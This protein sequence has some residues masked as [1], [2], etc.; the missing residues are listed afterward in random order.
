M[1]IVGEYQWI[2]LKRR[3]VARFQSASVVEFG[4]TAL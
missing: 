3:Q 4:N 1:T 2:K